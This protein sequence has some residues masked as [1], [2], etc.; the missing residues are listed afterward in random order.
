MSRVI[1]EDEIAAG[2]AKL[3]RTDAYRQA[4][5]ELDFW[6]VMLIGPAQRVPRHF[7]DNQGVRD[8]RVVATSDPKAYLKR[9]NV[10]H[11]VWPRKILAITWTLSGRHAARLKDKLDG[12]LLGEAD[13]NRLLQGWRDLEDDVDIVWPILLRQA[14]SEINEREHIEVFGEDEKVERIMR[15]AGRRA[16]PTLRRVK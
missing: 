11:G 10:E 12:M 4:E 14:V 16:P 5:K 15:H 6:S 1:S 9:C 3:K 8:V 13:K 2:V 7:G